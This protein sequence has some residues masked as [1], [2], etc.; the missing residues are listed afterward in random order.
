MT[1]P[2]VSER[3]RKAAYKA[4]ETLRRKREAA[5][6]PT[7]R[8]SVSSGALIQKPSPS[9][10]RRRKAWSVQDYPANWKEIRTEIL[11]RSADASGRHQCE[12]RGECR[13]HLGGCGEINGAAAGYRRQPGKVPIR[14]TIAHLCHTP[15]ATTERI[16]GR[17]ASP[18]TS[19]TTSGADSVLLSVRLRWPGRY[20]MT[21][22]GSS[23]PMGRTRSEVLLCR[24]PQPS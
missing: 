2:D 23:K 11:M 12:C 16:S 5:L 3:Q 6:D 8:S 20:D 18:V 14:L 24:G 10:G 15:S 17:C 7:S 4:W 21:S 1:T 9:E 13:K 22:L 19:S